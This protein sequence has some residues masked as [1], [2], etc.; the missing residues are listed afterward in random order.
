MKR[1][2][3]PKSSDAVPNR[4][5]S[6]DHRR[7]WAPVSGG[8]TGL[9]LLAIVL[10]AIAA[11][12]QGGTPGPKHPKIALVLEGGGALGLAHIGVIQWLEEHHIP[13]TYVTG[14]SMGGLVG[15]MYATGHSSKEMRD[16]IAAIDW[17]AVIGGRTPYQD[18]SF[19]RKE[20]HRDYPNL[21]EFG[22]RRGILFPS[23]F[24]TG[25]QVGLIFDRIAL[26]YSTIRTF[27]DLPIPF[28]CVSTDLV[29]GKPHV[30]RS[31][32]L[33]EALRSTM[34][35]PGVFSPV[36]S[37]DQLFADGALLDNLPVDVAQQMGAELTL[38]IH[39]QVKELD[40]KESLSSIGVLGR[41]VSVMIA[42]NELRSMEKAD[43]L[44]SVPLSDFT[45]L[46][47]EKAD[48]LIKRGYEAAAAKASVLSTLSVD[49]AAWNTYVAQRTARR[50][51]TLPAPQFVEV[52]G[53]P[54]QI[55]GD[56][57]K[58]LSST[59]GKPLDTTELDQHL[60]LLTGIGRFSNAGYRVIE[61]DGKTGLEI[62]A[63]EKSYAPPTVHPIIIIDGS[64]YN[65][66]HFSMGARITL[67]DLGAFGREWRNDVLVGSEYGLFSEYYVP[68]RA[69]SQWFV[70]PRA[71]LD[72][73]LFDA[74]D[75]DQFVAEYRKRRLGG[76][77]DFGR[78]FGRVAELRVGYEAYDLKL[79]PEIG[80]PNVLPTVQGRVGD[81]RT[82]FQLNRVDDPVIPRSGQYVQFNNDWYDA[83]PR[84]LGGFDTAEARIALFQRVSDLSSLYFTAAGGTSFRYQQTGVPQFSLGGSTRGLP[85]YG[86]NELLTNQYFLFIAGYI[87]QLAQLPPFLGD[88]IYF[89]SNYQIGKA[90]PLPSS[91]FSQAPPLSS[92]LPMSG[93]AGIVVNTIFGPI[94]VG[95]AAGDTGHHR[96]FFQLGKI[97]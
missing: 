55:A 70:A 63:I 2:R 56:I 71:I 66:V 73:Q 39:L 28:A 47:Y 40:P 59:I 12:A 1:F 11:A 78:E 32:S 86:M 35:L 67:Y 3:I 24:N 34:S 94:L 36:R 10:S 92:R 14:T 33:A 89:V 37:G 48:A 6:A 49:E 51:T 22:L 45:A 4:I 13:A 65:N 43:I 31:G 83:A 17:P 30:F 9:A 62:V 38:A 53:V 8:R 72:T 27:D 5:L 84:A 44:V 87:R 29:A 57:Q 68:F 54:P 88:H 46:D 97:F 91:A 96:F 79:N 58:E 42:A 60:M 52:I 80:N 95:G 76:G 64:D 69:G 18:Y 61:K 20:D 16:L 85:A 26:P 75:V 21:L 74:Y 19:R 81:T 15:G 25:Q 93:A 41:S 23:G 82:R 50:R 90:Y 77:L 7:P